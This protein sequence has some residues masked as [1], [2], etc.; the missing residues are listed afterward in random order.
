MAQGP[1]RT[2]NMVKKVFSTVL[3]VSISFGLLGLLFWIMRD[4]IGQIG[5]ILKNSDLRYIFVALAIF[6]INIG[7]LAW[8]LKIIFGGENLTLPMRAP[9]ALRI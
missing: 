9:C 3:R 5:S 4:E 8:R 7:F 2:E 1:D 6:L